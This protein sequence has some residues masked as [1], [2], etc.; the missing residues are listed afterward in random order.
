[1]GYGNPVP[2]AGLAF[3]FPYEDILEEF[4]FVPYGLVFVQQICQVF[5]R[6]HL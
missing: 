4:R 5:Q 2:Y 6:F 1:M 3:P